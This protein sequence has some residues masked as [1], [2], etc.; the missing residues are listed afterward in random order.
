MN[1]T[2]QEIRKKKVKANDPYYLNVDI[3]NI[4]QLCQVFFILILD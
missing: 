2:V 4:L 1:I 3:K